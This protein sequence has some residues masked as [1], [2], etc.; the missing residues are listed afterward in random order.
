MAM[1]RELQDIE[2]EKETVREEQ[3]KAQEQIAAAQRAQEAYEQGVNAIEAVLSEAEAET[4]S[5]DPDSGKTTLDDPTPL[6]SAPPKLRTQIVRLAKRL[7]YV[8]SNLFARIFRLD[9]QIKR[10]K[11]FL[12]RTDITSEA[13]LEARAVV[14]DVAK[15]EPSLG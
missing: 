9:A 5:Y 11:T 7:A 4:L 2:A 15:E 1:V 8:E 12:M 10:V 3:K 14:G 6:K 13:Q